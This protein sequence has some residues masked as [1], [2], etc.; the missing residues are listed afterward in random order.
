[1]PN[2]STDLKRL[3]FKQKFNAQIE[4]L[5]QSLEKTKPVIWTGDLNVAHQPIDLK[6]PKTN[7]KNAGFTLEERGDFTRIL[8]G[9]PKY[10]DSWRHLHPECVGYTY[11][12]Y[13]F[14][15]RVK[16]I[17]WRYALNERSVL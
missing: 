14:K 1:M 6:N 13:R 11:Y 12:S 4:K 16:R 3:P 7:T 2:A 15:C 9:P 5:M 17:G 8:E 10:V